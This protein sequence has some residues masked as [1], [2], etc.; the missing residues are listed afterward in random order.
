MET[1]LP[2]E[3]IGGYKVHPAA[4]LFPLLEG[5]DFT[6]L[7]ESIKTYGLMHPII[8]KG[9]VLIDGRNR[10]RAVREA[11]KPGQIVEL[12]TVELGADVESAAEYIYQ[13]NVNRRNLTEDQIASIGSEVVRMI[14]TEKKAKREATQFKA[15]NNANP[16]GKN[17]RT[18]TV[19]PP[20]PSSTGKEQ[21]NTK[22][23][24]PVPRD[25]KKS[26]EQS[27]VGQ[28]AKLTKVSHH[29]ARQF[30]AVSKAVES[31]ALPKDTIAKV[32]SGEVKLKDVAPKPK[33]KELSPDLQE[34]LDFY[35]ITQALK[36]YLTRNHCSI[37]FLEK[38]AKA[39]LLQ[40]ITTYLEQDSN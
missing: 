7:V 39:F 13:I 14:S 34:E 11:N 20:S 29:K 3:V 8:V 27:T 10:L 25:R 6:D 30:V 32:S 15:G 22:P 31:G 9:N 40:K 12:R 36:I 21:V 38:Q 1:D 26:D 16:E 35:H 23:C 2:L 17:Q 28:I 33:K 4:S 19:N 37:R 5:E 24:S 18:V